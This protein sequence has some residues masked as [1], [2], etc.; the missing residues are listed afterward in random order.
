MKYILNVLVN[1]IIVIL[2]TRVWMMVARYIGEQLG[3]SN[4]AEYILSKL[5]KTN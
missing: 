4:L 3:I 2:I 1:V 5:K